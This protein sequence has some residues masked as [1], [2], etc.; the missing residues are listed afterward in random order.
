[1]S[2]P[3]ILITAEVNEIHGAAIR[4]MYEGDAEVIVQDSIKHPLFEDDSIDA[5]YCGTEKRVVIGVICPANAPAPCQESFG[6]RGR[7][8]DRKRN[9]S[10]RWR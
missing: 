7:K 5:V 10:N 3:T 6:K 1:M 9:R 8:S 2:K 4:A